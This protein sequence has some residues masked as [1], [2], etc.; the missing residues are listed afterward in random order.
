MIASGAPPG[1]RAPQD[2]PDAQAVGR[3]FA[4]CPDLAGI[5]GGIV[6]VQRLPGLSNQV[7]RLT[8]ERGVFVLRL[9]H[10]GRPALTDRWAEL[11][12]LRLAAGIG[13][14][15]APLF[16]DPGRGL[17]LLPEVAGTPGR[18]EPAQLGEVLSRLH[19]AR[20]QFANR[21]EL[22]PWIAR[23]RA[24][25]RARPDPEGLLKR[26]ERLATR[27]EG[28]GAAG[29]S[30]FVPSHWDIIPGNCLLTPDGPVLI[31]WEYSAMGPPAWDLSYAV[32]E[33]DYT[34]EEERTLLAAY[35]QTGGAPVGEADVQAMKAVCD[36]VSA[37]WALGQADAMDPAAP[38]GR[39]ALHRI[40]RA[41]RLF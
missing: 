29:S 18:P 37:L 28:K 40:E 3:A 27:V 32:L 25:V 11:E 33:L 34:A 10:A 30:V 20:F 15:P 12:N 36:V 9:P 22:A 19:G 17:L 16:A 26:L 2:C 5:T 23:L 7:F 31:D 13:L 39:F 4:K 1:G 24:L 14:T 21:R 8:S 41:E 35:R 6:S 38:L